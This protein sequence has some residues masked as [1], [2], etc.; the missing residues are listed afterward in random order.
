MAQPDTYMITFAGA[1]SLLGRRG[2]R[3]RG[4]GCDSSGRSDRRG[5][6]G[7]WER[8]GGRERGGGGGGEE[9]RYSSRKPGLLTDLTG[10]QRGGKP[11]EISSHLHITSQL[12]D[13][14]LL[15][16]QSNKWLFFFFFKRSKDNLWWYIN[17][18]HKNQT[19]CSS[20]VPLY[21]SEVNELNLCA[22]SLNNWQIL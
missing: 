9:R 10:G 2:R 8:R 14:Q 19:I 21:N 6:A 11:S 5:R 18:K 17:K 12:Y 20:L 16:L 22:Y 13:Q 3:G 15:Q 7:G 1:G 4:G